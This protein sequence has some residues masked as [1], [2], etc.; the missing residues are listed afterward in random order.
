MRLVDW[1]GKRMSLFVKDM[2]S[3]KIDLLKL[4]FACVTIFPLVYQSLKGYFKKRN[5]AQFF[6]PFAYRVTLFT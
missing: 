3:D 1:A 6:H 5:T 4:V 2:H